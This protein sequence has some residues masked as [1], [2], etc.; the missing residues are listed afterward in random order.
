MFLD[1]GKILGGGGRKTYF[2]GELEN[3]LL[4]WK[5]AYIVNEDS[6]MEYK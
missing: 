6:L 3:Q 1:S 2:S 4:S 5:R